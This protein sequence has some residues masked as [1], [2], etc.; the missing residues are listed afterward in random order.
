MKATGPM[1]LEMVRALG[2]DLNGLHRVVIDI[3]MDDLVVV[4][5]E[6]DKE[7]DK[8]SDKLKREI[9]KYHLERVERVN[10]ELFHQPIGWN[11]QGE[12]R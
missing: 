6:R 5:V 12:G 10:Q 7:K 9:A 3:K 4:T 2:I 8:D 11:N 1:M